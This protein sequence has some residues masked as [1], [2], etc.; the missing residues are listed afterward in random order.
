MCTGVKGRI[1][2]EYGEEMREAVIQV[3]NSLHYKINATRNAALFN[4]ILAA[5]TYS[6]KVTQFYDCTLRR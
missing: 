1:I 6:L 4:I 5:G 2:D 3:N